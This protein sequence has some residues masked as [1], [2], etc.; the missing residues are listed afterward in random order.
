MFEYFTIIGPKTYSP[1]Q[2]LK[3]FLLRIRQSNTITVTDL[4][5]NTFRISCNSECRTS[6]SL[7]LSDKDGNK[8]DNIRIQVEL[9]LRDLRLFGELRGYIGSLKGTYELMRDKGGYIVPPVPH[10]ILTD[11]NG[12]PRETDFTLRDNGLTAVYFDTQFSVFY[13]QDEQQ[14][15]HI[16]NPY[17]ELYLRE[18]KLQSASERGELSYVIADSLADFGRKY[19]LGL[20]PADFYRYYKKSF[21]IIC[22]HSFDIENVNRKVFVKPMIYEINRVDLGYYTQLGD[23]ASYLFMDKIRKGEILHDTLIRVLSQELRIADDYV[24]AVVVN[25]IE[26]DRDKEGILIPRLVLNVFVDQIK[27]RLWFRTLSERS[28]AS[29]HTIGTDKYKPEWD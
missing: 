7:I 2:D 13:A 8:C 23:T 20:I 16:I 22:H 25:S 9:D 19:S 26:F 1:E 21:K 12:I 4:P 29:P 6:L 3:T 5:D 11:I 18:K 14:K 15:V 28:W 10:L 27:D 24:G 17:L